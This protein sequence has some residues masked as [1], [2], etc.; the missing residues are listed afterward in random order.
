MID[1]TAWIVI[2]ARGGSVGVPRKNV[3]LLAGRPLI[4]HAIERAF[5]VV[6][7]E[8]T[9]VVTDDA[10]IAHVVRREGAGVVLE[11]VRTPDDETLDT[12]ILRSIPHLERLGAR[13]L[14][15]LLTIQ[16]TS[17]LVSTASIRKSLGVFESGGFR[18]V[19]S[20]VEDR[21]L[22]WTR[23]ADGSAV[24]LYNQRKNRQDLPETYRETGAII[25]STIADIRRA[26][27]R[28]IEPVFL[29]ETE[30]NESIDIDSF[31][32]LYAA[33]HLSTRLQIAIRT[34]ASAQ[35]GMGHVYRAQ[36]ISAELARHSL[37]IFTSAREPLGGE[38]FSRLPY[39]HEAIRDEA[40]FF[41]R[42]ASHQPDL[43]LLDILDTGAEL[44]EQIRVAAPGAKVVTFEDLGPGA[45]AADLLVAEFVEHPGVPSERVMSGIE[46]SI[47]GPAFEVARRSAPEVGENVCNVLVLFG[48]TDP[49]QLATRALDSLTRVGY[50]ETVTRVC[51]MGAAPTEPKRRPYELRELRDVKFMPEVMGSADLAFTS[52]GRTLIE[53]ATM[54]I[55]SLCLAQ[56]QKELQHTHASERYGTWMLGLGNTLPDSELDAA[57]HRMLSDQACRDR[58]AR[59]GIDALRGRTNHR[60]LGRIFD[61]LGFDPFPNL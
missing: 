53:L 23:S 19:I 5:E 35:L 14:D 55:P 4:L 43:V 37:R 29:L 8:H 39:K 17:P 7:H 9:V 60:T 58:L 56:N 42:L 10:E 36:A 47:I 33:A 13:D 50:S 38:F 34:D 18:S 2:P 16:P 57:L 46:N 31:A 59:Q 41:A 11:D 51:G 49:S 30:S 3:R 21:H 20:V 44:I 22:R 45:A 54:G 24:P 52:A 6:G 48:G 12:K 25:A 15:V 28:V 40:E 1:R 61:H 27:T 26:E 32:D